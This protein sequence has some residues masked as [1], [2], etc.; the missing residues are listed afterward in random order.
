[1]PTG[2][3][4]HWWWLFLFMGYINHVSKAPNILVIF[5]ISVSLWGEAF[6]KYL[7]CLGYSMLYS[8]VL[9]NYG[10]S[11]ILVSLSWCKS[12]VFTWIEWWWCKI[13]DDWQINTRSVIGKSITEDHYFQSLK[14]WTLYYSVIRKS[15]HIKLINW[16]FVVFTI[17]LDNYHQIWAYLLT[18]YKYFVSFFS[19][20]C[21]LSW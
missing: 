13:I 10:P 3:R 15:F 18:N 9:H 16:E 6:G 21:A 17:S 7:G 4:R 5:S 14:K 8:W 19:T 1:M 11:R 2:E 20:I 12:G